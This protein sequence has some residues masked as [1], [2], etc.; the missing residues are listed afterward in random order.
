[1]F[2]E[3]SD[4]LKTGLPVIDAQHQDLIVMLNR[5]GRL[6]CGQESFLETFNELE[7]YSNIHFKTEEDLMTKTNY[8]KYQE[9]KSCHEKLKQ[10]IKDIKIEIN[11]NNIDDFGEKLH[12]FA[13]DW[14]I[15]HY[16][17]EDVE[18]VE[19]IKSHS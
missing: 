18:L 7:D 15:S 17:T 3:W 8:P 14:I 10:M 19:Y 13:Q 16:S 12:D 2:I 4:K 9:H 11:K 1:M 5:L 6:R